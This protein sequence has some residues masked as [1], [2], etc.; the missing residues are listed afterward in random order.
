M[1]TRAY[2]EAGTLVNHHERQVKGADISPSGILVS[3]SL[4]GSLKVLDLYNRA[5]QGYAPNRKGGRARK[6]ALIFEKAVEWVQFVDDRR[7]VAT[8]V[9]GEVMKMWDVETGRELPCPQLDA[10]DPLA[11]DRSGR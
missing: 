1:Y 5:A 9:R 8:T 3:G 6:S 11:F 2:G 10:R 4:D 7:V